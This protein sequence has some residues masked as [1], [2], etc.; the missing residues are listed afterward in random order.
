MKKEEFEQEYDRLISINDYR[1]LA[2][3]LRNTQFKSDATRDRALRMA[4]EYDEQADIDD[5]LLEGATQEQ[6]DAYAFISN[7]PTKS[8]DDNVPTDVYSK[9]F[10]DA[11]NDMAD[12]NGVINLN[13]N[14]NIHQLSKFGYYKATGTSYLDAFI[15]G[16]GIK[17][18]EFENYGIRRDKNG[19]HINTDNPNKIAI[20]KGIKHII[21][22]ESETNNYEYEPLEY[23]IPKSSTSRFKNYKGAVD[24]YTG[25]RSVKHPFYDMEDVTEK[26]NQEYQILMEQT[27]PYILQT[28]VTGYMGEDD[29]RLQEAFAAGAFDLQ[30]FKE[31]R[32]LLEEKYNRLLQNSSLTQLE[33]WGM[34]EDN[35][36]SEYLEQINDNILRAQLDDEINQAIA[37]GRLHYAHASNGLMYGTMITIDQKLDN[38]GNPVEGFGARKL[39]VKDLFRSEAEN[40]LRDDTQT[41]AQLK[42]AKHQTYG[43]TYRTKSGAKIE[44]WTGQY[45]DSAD[46]IDEYGNIQHLGKAELL[47]IMDDDII[48]R[49]IIDYY[50]KALHTDNKGNFYTEE[51]RKIFGN[52]KRDDNILVNNIKERAYIAMKEKYG[53]NSDDYIN[54]KANKL[55]SIIMQALNLNLE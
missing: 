54:F 5:K 9:R 39:F 37:D 47:N 2:N 33:V 23:I 20:Y 21:D 48:A 11:W 40:S 24:F 49:R 17:I 18:E 55:S 44:N 26:A 6:K 46:Y 35:N 32:S 36:G 4:E 53:N 41:D 7:G 30:T 31:A 13:L 1:G 22:L 3:L 43:H 28:V 16:S 19:F 12:E 27:S 15:E 45:G 25:E 14:N 8:L 51:S 50:K 29:K 38:K 52:N 42:Y 34:N 10:A